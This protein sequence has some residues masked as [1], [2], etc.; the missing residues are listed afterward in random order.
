MKYKLYRVVGYRFVSL[1]VHVFVLQLEFITSS[2]GT[3]IKIQ[4]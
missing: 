4:E 1:S 2:P 3:W